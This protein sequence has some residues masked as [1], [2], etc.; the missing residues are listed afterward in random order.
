[1]PEQHQAIGPRLPGHES[2]TK[3][4]PTSGWGYAWQY[5]T[6]QDGGDNESGLSGDNPDNSRYADPNY[7]PSVL[8]T[9]G[10]A[11]YAVFGS[12]N[13]AGFQMAFCDGSVHVMSYSTDFQV[14]QRLANRKDGLKI[15]GQKL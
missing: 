8:D 2:Q 4:L 10:I 9:P 12:A 15:D 1:M 6:G 13:L 11:T 5:E 14:E 7:G 3:R